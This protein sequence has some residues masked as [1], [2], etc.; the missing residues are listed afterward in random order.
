MTVSDR[1]SDYHYPIENILIFCS[2][3]CLYAKVLCTTITPNLELEEAVHILIKT[4]QDERLQICDRCLPTYIHGIILRK[5]YPPYIQTHPPHSEYVIGFINLFSKFFEDVLNLF[6]MKLLHRTGI[7][8]TRLA[9]TQSTQWPLS[10]TCLS[11]HNLQLLN[12]Y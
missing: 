3:I 8:W 4:I 2:Q 11:K 5:L 9:T 12:H 1:L 6:P 7:G 10:S